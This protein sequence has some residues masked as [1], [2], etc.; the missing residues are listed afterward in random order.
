MMLS[1]VLVTVVLQSAGLV[2]V[3]LLS[4]V[5]ASLQQEHMVIACAVVV[6]EITSSLQHSIPNTLIVLQTLTKANVI[7]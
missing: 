2:T 3:V 5:V 7:Y 4:A 6:G 1:A